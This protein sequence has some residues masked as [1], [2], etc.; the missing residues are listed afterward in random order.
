MEERAAS[1]IEANPAGRWK[2]YAP[3]VEALLVYVLVMVVPHLAG[4]LPFWRWQIDYYQGCPFVHLFLLILLP[5]AIGVLCRRSPLSQGVTFSDVKAQWRIGWRGAFVLVGLAAW[6]IEVL[7]VFGM[8]YRTLAG[9]VVLMLI[10]VPVVLVLTRWLV[11]VPQPEITAPSGKQ[12][13]IFALAPVAALGAMTAVVPVSQKASNILFLFFLIGLGEELFYRGY[14]Q[15]RLNEVFG[16]PYVFR[17]ISWGPGLVIT[18]VLFGLAHPIGQGLT[19][20][21]WALWT[22]AMGITLGLIR[23]KANSMLPAAFAHGLF[24][25]PI[26]F[27]G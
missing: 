1:I 4:L 8:G 19:Q 3:A 7:Q 9:A 24:D 15:G 10:E 2:K 22:A 12:L 27:F 11:A 6:P 16:R 18:A 13:L 5:L 20:W 25:V 14:I 17:G 21:P 23:E 26:A